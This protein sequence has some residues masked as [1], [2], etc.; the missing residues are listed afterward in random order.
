MF[1]A[2]IEGFF[3]LLISFASIFTRPIS[4]IINQFIPDLG[5]FLSSITDL[6]GLVMNSIGWFWALLPPLTRVAILSIISFYITMMP[7]R[8]AIDSVSRGLNLIKRINIF[9]SK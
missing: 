9:S 4:S 7:L 5:N 2:I 6:L 8:V 1:K 3:N